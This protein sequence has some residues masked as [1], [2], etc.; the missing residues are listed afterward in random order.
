M[1]HELRKLLDEYEVTKEGSIYFARRYSENKKSWITIP[2]MHPNK[3]NMYRQVEAVKR[4]WR[5]IGA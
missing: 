1:L 4:A 2:M 3:E 5:D